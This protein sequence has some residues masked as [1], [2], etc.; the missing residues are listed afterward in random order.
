MWEPWNKYFLVNKKGNH[1]KT[2][3]GSEYTECEETIRV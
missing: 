1:Y 3:L 2:A